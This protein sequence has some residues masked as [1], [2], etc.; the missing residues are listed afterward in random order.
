MGVINQGTI[1]E[2]SGG[3]IVVNAEPFN[4]QGSLQSI[5]GALDINCPVQ[6]DGDGR[7]MSHAS[8]LTMFAGNLLGTTRNAAYYDPQGTIQLDGSGTAE[9]PQLFEVMSRDLGNAPASYNNNFAYGTIQLAN[10][11]CVKLVDLSHNTT[12]TNPEALYVSLLIVP[13]GC[14]LEL[15]GLKVY[16]RLAQ[17]SG[18]LVGGDISQTPDSGAIAYGASTPGAISLAGELDEWSFTGRGGRSA[19]VVVNPG[20]TAP[21]AVAPYLGYAQVVLLNATNGVVAAATNTSYGEVVALTDVPLPMD[22]VYRVQV[23]ASPEHPASSGNYLITVWDVTANVATLALNR[24]CNGSMETPYSVDRW[25]FSAVAGQQV[26]FNLLNSSGSAIAFDFRGPGNWGGFTNLATSSDLITLPTSGTYT[27]T[28]HG[29]GGQYG[30][31]YA[32]RMDETTLT[33]VSLG[34]LAQGQLVGSGQAQIYRF[35][36]SNSS[37]MRIDLTLVN[38]NGSVEMYTKLGSAPTRSTYDYRYRGTNSQNES[39]LIPMAQAG[40]WYVLIY[41]SY[42]PQ[43]TVFSLQVTVQR[44]FLESISTKVFGSSLARRK[45]ARFQPQKI[46]TFWNQS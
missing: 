4:N 25:T 8:D 34:S 21:A 40:S 41:G 18:T 38:F 13:A 35:D 30:G 6:I 2:D 14:I 16:A 39:I 28:A 32:F 17:I 9:I 36:V 19:T 33:D 43:V 31:A 11:T 7:L 42:V 5:G 12:S 10:N 3:T 20:S 15:N 24:Q 1:S 26:R 37:P 23:R 45:P 44:I 46:P 27:L 29:T 22:G